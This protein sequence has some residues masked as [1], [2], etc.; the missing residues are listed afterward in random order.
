MSQM[1]LLDRELEKG[2][3]I[4]RLP[5]MSEDEFFEFCT[6]NPDL[7]A[8]R[9]SMGDIVLMAPSEGF[10]DNRGSEL[11]IDLGI[12]N[13]AL[14]E[15]GMTFGS[16]AGFT[17]PNGAVRSPDV[18][19]LARSRWQALTADERRNFPHIAPDFVAELMSPSD[20]LKVAQ[21]KMDEYLANG[22]RLGWLIDR[23]SRTVY[24]Y[25]PG[26]PVEELSDPVSV[27]GDPELP[28][29][30]VNMARVLLDTL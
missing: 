15:P 8:E 23:K 26:Q 21:E 20:R 29:L 19:W 17:L 1:I 27:S 11:H 13:R 30:V 25:R 10:T 24:V 18:A 22:V 12:W 6:R 3:G 2:D 7:N 14:P 16:S 28:G 9:N 4:L 5:V